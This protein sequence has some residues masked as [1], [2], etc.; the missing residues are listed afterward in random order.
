MPY[1][2]SVK[3]FQSKTELEEMKW[4][5]S[6]MDPKNKNLRTERLTYRKLIIMGFS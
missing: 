2:A 5:I 3:E 4:K 6:C 1:L